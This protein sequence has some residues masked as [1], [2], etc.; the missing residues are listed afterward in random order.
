MTER[1]H[2]VAYFV[3]D[4]T[5]ADA[6]AEVV[7]FAVERFGGIDTW[8][9]CAGVG[10]FGRAMD[11]SLEDAR[12][13]VDI[14][15]WG[16]VHGSRTAIDYV[17]QREPNGYGFALINI[18]SVESD[19]AVPLHSFY[20]AS[21]HALKGFTD[22]LRMELEEAG[23]PVSVTLIKP[24][25]IDTP[26]V[27]HA[28]NLMDKEGSFPPP[29]YAPELVG[30]A[31]L[32]AA[33]YPRR[34]LVVGGGGWLISRVGLLAPR[35]ADRLMRR[36]FFKMQQQ[37]APP[38]RK[39]ALRSPGNAGGNERGS[40]P[41]TVRNTS[42]YTSAQLHPKAVQFALAAVGVAAAIFLTSGSRTR[43]TASLTKG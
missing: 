3:A 39:H 33:R 17:Q 14:D 36:T 4:V 20:S 18:G 40:Y 30:E 8:V 21:K 34:D 25:P 35:L 22:A 32:H 6:L 10:M 43:S 31:I 11:I 1:G 19:R 13:L 12:R 2:D 24:G 15:F 16:Q 42:L 9:N 26:F 28:L 38:E 27:Q 5:D 37:D 23:L 29:V 7:D 41:G